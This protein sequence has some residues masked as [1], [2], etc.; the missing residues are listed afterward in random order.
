MA[1]S[2]TAPTAIRA[3]CQPGIPPATMVRY[4]IWAGTKAGATYPAPGSGPP[5]ERG[6]GRQDGGGQADQDGGDTVD[7]T[8]GVHETSGGDNLNLD[9]SRTARRTGARLAW[10]WGAGRSERGRT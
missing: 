9:R 3:I 10:I 4:W 5:G 2:R 6:R 8:D 1:A 7:V